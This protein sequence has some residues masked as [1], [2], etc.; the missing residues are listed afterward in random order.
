LAFIVEDHLSRIY[1]VFHDMGARVNMMQNS[2]VSTSFC[3]NHDPVV[4]PELI[5]VLEEDFNLTYTSNLVLY[6]VR[7]YNTKAREELRRGKDVFME[8][9]TPETYQLVAN[10]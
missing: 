1:Q 10:E 9:I 7:H 3:I 8:Q 4:I 5:R 6:S 2:A